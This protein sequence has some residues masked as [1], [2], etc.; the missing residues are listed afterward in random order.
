MVILRNVLAVLLG[1]AVGNVVNMLLVQSGYLI[2]PLK[3][4]DMNDMTTLVEVIP[5]LSAKY[6]I[7]PFLAHAFGTLVGAIIAGLIA[8]NHK[9]KFSLSIGGLFLVGGI[10][11]NFMLPGPTWFA[12]LDIIVAYIPMAWLGGKIALK[13]SKNNG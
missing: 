12:I 4:V 13:F 9:M 3:G 11:I 10:L 1:F 7:F 2:Y 6:F 8:A 5:T